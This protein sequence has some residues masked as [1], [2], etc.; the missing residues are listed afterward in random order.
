MISSPD[1]SKLFN[2]F[3]IGK[4]APTLVSNR[5]GELNFNDAIFKSL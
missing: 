1:E 2:V 3:K 5:N 4:P